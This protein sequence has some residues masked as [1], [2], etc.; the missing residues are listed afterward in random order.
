MKH[1]LAASLALLGAV[2]A[3]CYQDD[4]LHPA[5]ISPT[6]VLITDAPFPF[7]TVG[8]VSIYVSR[9]EATTD[10]DTTGTGGTWVTIDT[11]NKAFDLLTLQQGT[12]AFVGEGTI[13]AG[14]YAA[15]RMTIDVDR[16]SIKYL[17][18]TTAVVHWP[19]PATGEVPLYALVEEPLSVSAIGGVIVIDF[20]V[21]RSF[22]YNL[23]GDSDFVMFS[24]LRAVN[25]AGTG[26][27]AGVVT[28]PDIEGH[29][30]AI[31]NANITVFAG[32][33]SRSSLTWYVEAT[34][35]TDAAGTYKVAFLPP[36]KWIVRVEHPD[37]P[38]LDPVTIPNVIVTAG[39]TATLPVFL[40]RA[41]AG[42]T[43]IRIS[44]PDTVG[45]G[46]TIV[47]LAAVGDA[48]GIPEQSPQVSW[49]SRDT[50]VAA[51]LQDSGFTADSLS[52]ATVLGRGVGQ[53]WIVASS[54][55]L[56]DSAQIEVVSVSPQSPVATITLNPSSATPA[57]GDSVGF[58]AELKDSNGNVLTNRQISWSLTD[59]SG[60]A[61]LVWF[62]G[63]NAL[64]F[65][66]HAGT[67]HLRAV[68]EGR[69]KDATITVP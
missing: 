34:G 23:T 1:M 10:L 15:I 13:D 9:I 69:Y 12:T 4:T 55:A 37:L 29:P 18:G 2:A 31:K 30:T 3:A 50:A 39:G 27:I 51:V 47:L 44:G 49:L 32:D 52:R 22:V 21:G 64:V 38:G 63:A 66:R 61:D 40:P 59:S 65:G 35:R 60:V 57:V 25:I 6:Q 46:G 56:H 11:P 19:Y 16:S 20:D 45:Y 62:S 26:S 14:R 48:S 41:G 7:D 58:K 28:V 68:S 43:F 54:G 8:S 42:G 5:A 36:G 17:D 24:S 33:P 67:T 53:A